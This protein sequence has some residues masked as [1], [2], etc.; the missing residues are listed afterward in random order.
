MQLKPD[1]S[2]GVCSAYSMLGTY[3]SAGT[4]AHTAHNTQKHKTQWAHEIQNVIM[5]YLSHHTHIMHSQHPIVH[6]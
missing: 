1:S 6:T 4:Q 5:V 2:H 3:S